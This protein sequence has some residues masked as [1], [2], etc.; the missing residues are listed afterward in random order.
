M[1]CKLTLNMKALHTLERCYSKVD[2]ISHVEGNGSSLGVSITFL[3]RLGCL[4]AI[5]NELDLLLSFLNDVRAK[6]LAF[7]I[8]GR[9]ERG[10]ELA[11]IE[12]FKGCHL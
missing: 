6:D 10:T 2:K 9:V 7:S 8:F 5:P 11:S 3:P 4:Q 1:G 12:S